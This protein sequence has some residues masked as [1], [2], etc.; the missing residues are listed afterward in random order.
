[1]QKQFIFFILLSILV[2]IF[3]I[4][5][6][7]IITVQLFFWSFQLSGS[8][9]ILISVALGACLVL[10]FGIYR[11]FKTRST[12]KELEKNLSSIKTQSELLKNDYNKALQDNEMLKAELYQLKNSVTQK[13]RGCNEI[14]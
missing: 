13:T 8:L 5:N 1:M 12:I 6:A 3:A 4:T 14:E 11:S 9:V 7:E 2:A 10:L